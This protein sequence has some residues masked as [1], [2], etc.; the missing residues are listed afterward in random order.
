MRDRRIETLYKCQ[1]N[2]HS[3]VTIRSVGPSIQSECLT[4]S[5]DQRAHALINDVNQLLL[6]TSFLTPRRKCN[7]VRDATGLS[8][9]SVRVF[10]D[11]TTSLSPMF[12]RD[13]PRII[14][15]IGCVYTPMA[16]L[17]RGFVN[18]WLCSAQRG[19]TA[20][21]AKMSCNYVKLGAGWLGLGGGVVVLMH[22]SYP[23]KPHPTKHQFA[24]AS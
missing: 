24:R 3:P 22:T 15:N 11:V 16:K 9:I 21:V 23:T 1:N 7:A 18:G 14:L 12:T 20:A 2:S 19:T 17:A 10:V 6:R 13:A 8:K 5:F 4:Y